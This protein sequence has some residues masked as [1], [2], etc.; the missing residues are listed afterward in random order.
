MDVA[1]RLSAVSFLYYLLRCVGLMLQ[2]REWYKDQ[3]RLCNFLS[4]KGYI[5]V[6]LKK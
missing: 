1:Y 6:S 3:D 2:M 5:F 4:D